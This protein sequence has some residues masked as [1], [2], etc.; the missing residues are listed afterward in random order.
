MRVCQNSPL[1]V[2]L[3]FIFCLC[4]CEKSESDDRDLFPNTMPIDNELLGEW[5][6]HLSM[7]DDHNAITIYTDSLEFNTTNFGSIN[8]YKFRDL[9]FSDTFYFYTIDNT[10]FLNYDD[11]N[12]KWNYSIRNDS[13]FVSGTFLYIR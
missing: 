5:H 3:M 13:L 11:R 8:H 12:E 10:I 2:T 1:I 6:R 7:R 9:W 4:S